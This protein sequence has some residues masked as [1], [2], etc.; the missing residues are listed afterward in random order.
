MYCS[1]SITLLLIACLMEVGVG[2]AQGRT[3]EGVQFPESVKAGTSQ[4]SLRGAG[5]LRYKVLFRG[6]VAALY[7]QE[8]GT[9]DAIDSAQ[10]L[11]IEYF[12]D[13]PANEF[14]KATVEGI[15]KN[16]N[17]ESFQNLRGQIDAFNKFYRDIESGDRYTL[18]YL[19]DRGTELAL[20]GK[21]LGTMPGQDFA[22]ALFGIW[23]GD[24]PLDESL[25]KKLLGE[26]IS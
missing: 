15:R 7:Q 12:W 6:Y 25:K 26:K 18:T 23:L 1:K 11:E 4:M 13:I 19:P 2:H 20:N 8:T 5:L 14:Q 16:T 3:V 21:S 10:R 9:T 24:Q 22:T 17:P